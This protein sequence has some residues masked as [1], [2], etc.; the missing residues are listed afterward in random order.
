MTK[1]KVIDEK[2][3]KVDQVKCNCTKKRRCTDPFEGHKDKIRRCKD[4][5]RETKKEKVKI[6]YSSQE[7]AS[8]DAQPRRKVGQQEIRETVRQK[9]KTEERNRKKSR[10]KRGLPE[11]IVENVDWIPA[12]TR[13]RG[14]IHS[15]RER[16]PWDRDDHD[17]KW[18]T[19]NGARSRVLNRNEHGSLKCHGASSHQF[20]WCLPKCVKIG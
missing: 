2:S 18:C 6:V 12:Q 9:L 13:K 5:L 15:P 17:R 3:N 16:R 7:K 19:R 1:H 11:M 10:H 4:P 8:N 14:T 20:C